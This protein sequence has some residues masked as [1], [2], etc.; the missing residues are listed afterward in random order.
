MAPTHSSHSKGPDL[1]RYMEKRL[2]LKLNG[3][4]CVV[5]TLRGY[6]GFMNI[7]LEDAVVDEDGRSG[8]ALGPGAERIGTIVI[9][10]SSVVQFES[11]ARV[12]A[13]PAATEG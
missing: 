8:P 10:G 7:V 6:D 13:E 4:R 5:G 12:S 11:L 3:P 2:R 1:K 9:R